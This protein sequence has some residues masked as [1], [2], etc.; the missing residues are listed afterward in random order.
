[1]S[2]QASAMTEVTVKAPKIS[3]EEYQKYRG[4]NVAIYKGKI[5]AAGDNSG[6][7]LQKALQKYPKVKPEEIA[8]DYIQ[9]ADELIL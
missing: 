8:I 5:V 1:M 3:P 6:E 7:A 4:K 2:M 9:V